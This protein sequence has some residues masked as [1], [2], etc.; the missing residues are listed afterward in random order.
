MG[1]VLTES[2]GM[3]ILVLNLEIAECAFSQAQR[4]QGSLQDKAQ[5]CRLQASAPKT[6]FMPLSRREMRPGALL[7]VMPLSDVVCR[8]A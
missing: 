4:Q 1:W 7:D 6:S 3:M 5:G 8:S 2:Q